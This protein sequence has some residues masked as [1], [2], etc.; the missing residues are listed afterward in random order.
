MKAEYLNPFL[1]AFDNVVEQVINIKAERGNLFIKEG[2]VKSGEVVI[3]IGV[4]GDLTGSVI[5]NM[6]ECA[7]KF[8]ASKMMFGMEVK[9]LDDMAKSAISELGNMIAGNSAGFFMEM[10]KNINITPPSMYTGSNMTVYAYKGKTLCVPMKIEDQVV[11]IDI[12]LY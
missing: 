8:V 10:G 7:A 12:S 1:K 4:T 9:E 5:L 6:S 3:N 2:S 11:E